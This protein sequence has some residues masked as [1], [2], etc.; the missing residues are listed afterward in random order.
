MSSSCRPN[1]RLVHLQ[2]MVIK[3][4]HKTRA[5]I[6]FADKLP[7]EYSCLVRSWSREETPVA[8]Y[9]VEGGGTVGFALLH[10]T[11]MDPLGEHQEPYVLD[12]IFVVS[13]HRRRRVA[14]GL[15]Q[16]VIDRHSVTSFVS[17]RNTPGL[18]LHEKLGFVDRPDAAFF[19]MCTYR[20]P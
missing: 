20:F 9:H 11:N 5:L 16:H 10:K 19:G 1:D 7:E 18:G 13:Q 2:K 4:T 8:Y 14:H 12:L 17:P 3:R 6:G 15:L